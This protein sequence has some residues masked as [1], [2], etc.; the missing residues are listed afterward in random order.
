MNT[1]QVVNYIRHNRD[2]YWLTNYCA[3][4][5]LLRILYDKNKNKNKKVKFI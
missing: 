4:D 1:F 5:I 2:L 3:V